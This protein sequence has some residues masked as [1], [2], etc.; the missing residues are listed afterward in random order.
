MC[1]RSR[2]ETRSTSS[3]AGII[4]RFSCSQSATIIQSNSR[5]QAIGRLRRKQ[6]ISLN[7]PEIVIAA[8][9]DARVG[10]GGGEIAN[11]AVAAVIVSAAAETEKG[12]R[13]IAGAEIG[14]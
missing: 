7:A 4:S 14:T 12:N 11:E 6:L 13:G 2:S 1:W 3:S 10:A 8:E 9:A 5:F